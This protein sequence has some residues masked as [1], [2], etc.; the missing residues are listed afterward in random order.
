[1]IN[2][3]IVFANLL[4]KHDRISNTDLKSYLEAKLSCSK[5]D[6]VRTENLGIHCYERQEGDVK[7]LVYVYPI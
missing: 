3:S 2:G 5:L 1:M 7:L 4:S 6:F